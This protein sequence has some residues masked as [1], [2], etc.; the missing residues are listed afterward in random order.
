MR[1]IDGWTLMDNVIF[2]TLMYI[3]RYLVRSASVRVQD[4]SED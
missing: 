1:G 2:S 3:S 4:I